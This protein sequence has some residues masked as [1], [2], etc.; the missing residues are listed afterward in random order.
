MTSRADRRDLHLRGR[1]RS[2]EVPRGITG[3]SFVRAL[4][5][6][7]SGAGCD[8]KI[9]LGDERFVERMQAKA[10]V[11][12]D[13]LSIPRAQRRAPPASLASIAAKSRAHGTRRCSQLTRRV[14]NSYRDIA[15]KSGGCPSRWA[16]DRQTGLFGQRRC[17]P[18]WQPQAANFPRPL[19]FPTLLHHPALMGQGRLRLLGITRSTETNE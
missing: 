13:E 8:R 17:R 15:Q 6:R 7:A 16:G 10:Q 12:G 9:Y 1:W 18:L 3:S 5:G 4:G 19:S 14:P 11:Q 2:A